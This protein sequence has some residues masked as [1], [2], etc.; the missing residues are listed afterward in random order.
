[1]TDSGRDP[2]E[3]LHAISTM[4]LLYCEYVALSP[5]CTYRLSVGH[6]YKMSRMNIPTGD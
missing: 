6:D 1:M 5:W 2:D 4:T 3:K